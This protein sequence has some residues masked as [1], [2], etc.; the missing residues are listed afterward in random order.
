M[1]LFTTIS[2]QITLFSLGMFC[3]ALMSDIEWYK[4]LT[5][6]VAKCSVLDTKELCDAKI[7]FNKAIKEFNN[8]D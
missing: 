1:S 7:N 3:G 4:T 5:N 6:E 2:L 8:A